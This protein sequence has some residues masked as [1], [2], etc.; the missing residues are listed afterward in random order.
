M[1]HL[2]LFHEQ[3]Q[4]AARARR[5]AGLDRNQVGEEQALWGPWMWRSF[6]QL[7]RMAEQRKGQLR[8]QAIRVQARGGPALGEPETIGEY[9]DLAALAAALSAIQDRLRKAW[10]AA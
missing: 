9:N 4:E 2:I 6:Y 5:E 7:S 8:L 1:R 3:Y 10:L